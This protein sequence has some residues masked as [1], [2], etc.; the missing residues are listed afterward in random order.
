M[1]VING[2][3]HESSVKAV[4]TA[5]PEQEKGA[6]EVT[7]QEKVAAEATK[8]G[9]AIEASKQE[10]VVM[11]MKKVGA[12]KGDEC[13]ESSQEISPSPSLD[14]PWKTGFCLFVL[15]FRYFNLFFASFWV[16]I[17]SRIFLA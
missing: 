3:V 13:H 15:N 8:R 4:T 6:T 9:V 7:K 5:V 11:D 1:V 14:L 10:M 2:S 17:I 12:T 16:K